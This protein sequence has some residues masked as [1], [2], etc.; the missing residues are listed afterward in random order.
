MYLIPADIHTKRIIRFTVT[1]QFTTAEDILKDWS[2]ISKTASTLLA[3]T[4]ALNNADQP[5]SVKDEAIEEN[6]DPDSDTRSKEREDAAFGWTRLKWS[7]GLTRLGIDLEDRCALLAAAASL[8]LT[9]ATGRCLAT[10]LK[11]G[12]EVKMLQAPSPP[13]RHQRQDLVLCLR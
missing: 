3:E 13:A 5:K 10:T 11:Q 6:Q 7:C 8:C 1:S 4:Q 2:I 9:L 12:L